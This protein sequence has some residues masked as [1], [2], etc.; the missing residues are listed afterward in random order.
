MRKLLLCLAVVGTCL[1]ITNA[2][3]QAAASPNGCFDCG[4][5]CAC[6]RFP[7]EPCRWVCC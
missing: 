3:K 6:V 2:P 4:G 1:T 7:G 5:C